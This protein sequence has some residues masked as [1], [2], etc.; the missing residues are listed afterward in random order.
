M[1]KTYDA[2]LEALFRAPHA[3]FVAERAR[4]ATELTKGG[5]AA[6]GKK[7]QKIRRPGITA[8]AV[9]QLWWNERAAFKELLRTAER[10]RDADLSATAAHKKALGTLRERAAAFLTEAGHAASEGTLRRVTTTLSALAATGGFEPDA[11]GTLRFDR[12]P[13]GFGAMNPKALEKLASRPRAK[14]SPSKKTDTGPSKAEAAAERRRTEREQAVRRAERERVDSSIRTT[15]AALDKQEL[16]LGE[17][18]TEVDQRSRAV[19]E[20]KQ[21]LRDLE[22]RRRTL[23]E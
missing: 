1:P 17:L 5:D 4:L 9:N 13:A 18:R 2:A 23:G 16:E 7:L 10:L 8:W 11:P 14:A 6:A 15:R 21:K 3:A 22:K 19:A 20:T 12:D